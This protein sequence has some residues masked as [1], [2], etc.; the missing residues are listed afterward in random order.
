MLSSVPIGTLITKSLCILALA[1]L[2]GCGGGGDSAPPMTEQPETPTTP[3]P[4]MMTDPTSGYDWSTAAPFTFS[5]V[6]FHPIVSTKLVMTD[7]YVKKKPGTPPLTN[8]E[9][10]RSA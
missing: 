7:I 10:R 4:P 3:E 1:T 2:F 8:I 6:L 5:N 9:R